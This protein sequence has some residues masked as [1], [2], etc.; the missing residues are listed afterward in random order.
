[1]MFPVP[2]M[3]T[4]FSSFAVSFLRTLPLHEKF[5]QWHI[6]CSENAKIPVQGHDPF[7]L[8][9]ANVA[10]TAIASCPMPLNHLEIFPCRNNNSILS[11]IILGHK[12]LR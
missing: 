8:L 1:M 7:I 5:T 2:K 3:K 10:P 11:S 9:Q 4:S 12:S 6:A